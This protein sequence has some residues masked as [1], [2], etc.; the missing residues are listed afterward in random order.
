MGGGDQPLILDDCCLEETEHL[1]SPVVREPQPD[2]LND[3]IFD[4]L[5]GDSPLRY[6]GF[7]QQGCHSSLV[8]Q[9]PNGSRYMCPDVSSQFKPVVGKIFLSWDEVYNMYETCGEMSGF[10]IRVGGYKKWKGEITH[11]VLV[12]NKAGKPRGK[13]VDSVNPTSMSGARSSCFKVT[14]CKAHIRLRATKGTT[15]HVLYE[16]SEN[17]NHELISSENMDLTRK[18]KHLNFDDLHFV[19]AMSLNRIGATVAHRLQTSLKG[20]HHNMRGTRNSYK[21]VSRDIRMFIGERDVQLVLKKLEERAKNLHK[22]SFEV[23]HSEEK[24]H[25]LMAEYALGN[26]IWLNEMFSIRELWVPFYFRDIPMCCLMKTT[27]RCESSNSVFKVTSGITNTLVQFLMCFDTAIDNQMYNQRVVDFKSK[28]Y[29]VSHMDNRSDFVNHFKVSVHMLEHSYECSCMGFT[30]VGY[31]CHHIFSVFRLHQIKNIPDRYISNR[32]RKRSLPSRVYSISQRLSTDN[33]EV[34]VLRN[35]VAD[36]LNECADHLAFNVDGLSSFNQ[37]MKEL[38]RELVDNFPET[39]NL[40][41]PHGIRNK[42]CGTNR[43]LVGPGEKAFENSKKNPRMCR[44][45]NQLTY[46]KKKAN[47][48]ESTS[49]K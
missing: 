24:W 21:N 49:E 3:D 30:R 14:G 28:M 34:S 16:F 43:R 7:D 23:Y 11:R 37:K 12:C 10:Q 27:S 15:N 26:H 1:L 33:S 46:C 20:G 40:L 9:T 41:P 8:Y 25:N 2:P 38:K 42:G 44:S 35:E 47:V 45:C 29:T 4:I 6:I 48:G 17:H 36:C 5:T 22:F 32:W 31:L 13:M 39:I 19:H 18:G